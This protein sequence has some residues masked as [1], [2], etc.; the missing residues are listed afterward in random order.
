MS[1]RAP[2]PQPALQT[3]LSVPVAT[4]GI[5]KAKNAAI[6]A[7]RIIGMKDILKNI[8]HANKKKV[9]DQRATFN[10]LTM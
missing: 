5:G 10:K 8:S 9:R 4:V 3:Y 1:E 7:L 6:L 2:Q